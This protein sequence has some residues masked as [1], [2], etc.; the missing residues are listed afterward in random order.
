MSGRN[1]LII[2]T[3]LISA[4]TTAA[5]APPA[6]IRTPA[7]LPVAAITIAGNKALPTDA[8]LAASGLRVDA[9][10]GSAIFDAAR[11][12]L[13]ASGYFDAVSYTF[14]QQDAGFAV[15]F[16]VK[17]MTQVYPLRID[18][19]PIT[20]TRLTELI[21]SNDPLFNGRLPGAKP[22]IDRAASIIEQ[23]LAATNPGLHVSAKVVAA[24]TDHF[25]IQFS[26][27]EGLPVIA[28]VTFEGSAVV[29]DSDL[30]T[31]MIENGIGQVFS[32]ASMRELLDRFIRPLFE[33]QGYMRVSFP[34]VT[35]KPAPEVKGIDVHV[36]VVDGPQFKLGGVSVR[37]SMAGD[38]RRILRIANVQ[39]S[40]FANG[41][42]VAQGVTRIHDTLR[43][44]GYLDVTVS[45]GHTIDDADKTVDFW[46]DVNP[47]DVYTFGHLE[48]LGL[49]LDGEAAIRKLWSVKPGDPFPGG[50]PDY[51]VSALK[52]ED[53]FDNLGGITATPAINRQTRVVDVSLHFASAPAKKR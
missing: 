50:Y 44:E 14:R 20:P 30:H 9:D 36:T 42:D 1:S 23:S 33:K 10:G 6:R 5:Q 27:A 22:V 32:E 35:S 40:D 26:P 46:F 2:L 53:L 12:R 34:N 41:D 18:A 39:H 49:G 11:D 38:S 24:G 21:K 29:K 37:G 7:V 16:T 4:A 48:V 8:I 15:A 45:T 3:A 28:D 13:L 52:G 43:G 25:E 31:E 19:L 17:E 47:G 51:F